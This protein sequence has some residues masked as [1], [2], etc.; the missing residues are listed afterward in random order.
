[1]AA[2][3]ANLD[4]GY[5]TEQLVRGITGSITEFSSIMGDIKY[6]TDISQNGIEGL[7]YYY[8]GAAAGRLIHLFFDFSLRE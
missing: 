3:F 7:N 5:I 4:P 6:F 2:Q 8:A 1:M